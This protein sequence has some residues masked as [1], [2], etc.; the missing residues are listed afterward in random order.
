M[1]YKKVKRNYF[2]IQKIMFKI[3]YYSIKLAFIMNC[4]KSKKRVV[5]FIN[6]NVL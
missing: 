1:L 5:F 6:C 4:E 3:E 2:L